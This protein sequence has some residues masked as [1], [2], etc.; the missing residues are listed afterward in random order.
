MIK[1]DQTNQQTIYKNKINSYNYKIIHITKNIIINVVVFL[2]IYL[3]SAVFWWVWPGPS[4]WQRRPA[5]WH[6]VNAPTGRALWSDRRP[7][8]PPQTPL[9]WHQP[10]ARLRRPGRSV[11]GKG[12]RLK[13]RVPLLLLWVYL[14]LLLLCILQGKLLQTLKWTTSKT[15]AKM[16]T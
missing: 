8:N 11:G 9:G 4:C 16:T 2:I 10:P 7:R 5:G 12:R 6:R 13:T 14:W 3:V 15:N 1:T